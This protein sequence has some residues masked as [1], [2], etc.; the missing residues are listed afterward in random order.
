MSGNNPVVS[1]PPG[2]SVP[3]S[4]AL[5][6]DNSVKNLKPEEQPLLSQNKIGRA[7]V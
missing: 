7:H 5:S 4:Y 2:L 3:P 6:A 1:M